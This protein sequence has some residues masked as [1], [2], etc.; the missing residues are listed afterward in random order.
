MTI[1]TRVTNYAGLLFLSAIWGSSFLFIKL[2]IETIHPSF[3]TFL[4]LLIASFFLYVYL[5]IVKKKNT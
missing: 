5:K 3:L 2:S 1:N 4:R